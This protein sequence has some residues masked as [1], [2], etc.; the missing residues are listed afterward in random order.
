MKTVIICHKNMSKKYSG[1]TRTVYEQIRFFSNIG[2]KTY[3]I[4]DSLNKKDVEE[5]QSDRIIFVKSF[6]W[7]WQ[8][9]LLRRL[10]YS[11]NV[12]RLIK[13]IDPDITISHGDFQSADYFFSH[14]NV[15]LA[16]ERIWGKAL[17]KNDEI[18]QTHVPVFREK[19]F[20]KI[21]A[22]SLLVKND[23]CERFS[24]EENRIE[25]IY[26]SINQDDFLEPSQSEIDALKSKLRINKNSLIVG[27]VT[28][29]DF[30][31]RNL[32]QFFEAIDLLPEELVKKCF[33]IFVG[34]D[35]VYPEAVTSLQKN[36][37]KERIKH[38]PIIDNVSVL[39]HALDLFI[40]P[41]RLEEFGRVVV[42]AMA[43]ATPVITNKWVG[44]SELLEGVSKK[45]IYDGEN[46]NILASMM[47]Q[48]LSDEKLRV[49]MSAQNQESVKV[50][51][52][53]NTYK[54]LSKALLLEP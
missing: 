20:K 54:K 15:C 8:K 45:F 48:I 51:L 26:P 38:V 33:F 53:E 24:I 14:N 31:K 39:F 37:Y 50:I 35:K 11:K 16:S 22:N 36:K 18:Y 17:N 5:T 10:Q 42:E 41:A 9:R 3:I 12:L 6:Y 27:L 34:R 49:E 29:G 1:A 7:P 25:V 52:E 28:S 4:A 47:E 23:L 2:Y 43:C 40:L 46:T 21:I 32:K 30:K 13:K 19:K 44:A